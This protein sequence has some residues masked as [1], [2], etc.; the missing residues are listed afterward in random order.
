MTELETLIRAEIAARGPMRFDRFMELALYEPGLG[1]YAKK[2][3]PAVIGRAGDFYTSVSVGPLFGRLLARQFWQM[4]QGM[5]KPERFWIVEQGANDGRLARDILEWCREAAPEFFTAVQYAIVDKDASRRAAQK[6]MTGEADGRVLWFENWEMVGRARPRG[7]FF[8]NELADALP[9]RSVVRRGGEWRERCVGIS[10]E[11]KLEWSEEPWND[12]IP[13][14][15]HFATEPPEVEG[16]ETEFSRTAREWLREALE[17][18]K[19]GYAVIID[20]GY[21]ASVYYASHRTRGTLT[22]YRN[23]QRS[24]DVLADPGEQDIT[25]HVNFTWLDRVAR[26]VVGFE[27]L[28]FLDQQRF[29]MGVAH[30]ELAGVEGP[31]TGIAGN[32]R[33]WNSLTRPDFLG[34]RFQALL[35][36]RNVPGKIDGSRFARPGGLQ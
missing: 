16:Y 32:V 12:P 13:L 29:L 26:Q 34:S 20:Y 14:H 27:T 1:Y 15:H 6:E 24:D 11:N 21:P 31:V 4:W 35:L 18:M 3:G 10:P 33:A 22:A 17:A 7:V 25:A 19:E 28:G 36:G 2:A 30:D 8:C 9:V 5:G 23:H